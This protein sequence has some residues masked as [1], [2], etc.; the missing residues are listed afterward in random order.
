MLRDGKESVVDAIGHRLNLRPVPHIKGRLRAPADE[1]GIA[2]AVIAGDAVGVGWTN[3]VLCGEGEGGRL[4]ACL[5][6]GVSEGH[7]EEEEHANTCYYVIGYAILNR[8]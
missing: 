2:G 7:E 8:S 6:D 3:V 5:V 4:G 1:S